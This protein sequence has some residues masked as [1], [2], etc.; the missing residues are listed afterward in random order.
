MQRTLRVAVVPFRTVGDPI[1]PYLA[2]VLTDELAQS[3]LT[4][5]AGEPYDALDPNL[6]LWVHA[7][8]VDSALLFERR[9]VSA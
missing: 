5:N 4:F 9:D 2:D 1:D 3:Y 8:L 6:L 7:V